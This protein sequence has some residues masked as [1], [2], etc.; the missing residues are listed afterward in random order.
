[1]PE[2]INLL[3]QVKR[4]VFTSVHQLRVNISI[5]IVPLCHVG[6]RFCFNIF[7]ECAFEYT[8]EIL[9]NCIPNYKLHV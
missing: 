8:L 5:I 1:M 6:V 7:V 2:C 9:E 4:P 3:C